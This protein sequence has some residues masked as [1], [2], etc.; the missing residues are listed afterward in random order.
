[1]KGGGNGSDIAIGAAASAFPSGA[2]TITVELASL[3]LEVTG[4]E[5]PEFIKPP[6]SRPTIGCIPPALTDHVSA[7]RMAYQNGQ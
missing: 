4:P 3:R 6:T 2:P 5:G 1:M 7:P